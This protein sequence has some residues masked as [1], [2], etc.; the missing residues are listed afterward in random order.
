MTISR[1]K[2]ITVAGGKKYTT[3]AYASIKLLRHL[4]CDLPVDWFYINE[5]E[6]PE[7]WLVAASIPGVQCINLKL[8]EKQHNGKSLGGW[9]AKI[10]AIL[11]TDADEVLYLDADNFVW[12]DPEYLFNSDLFK[13]YGAI[14][15]KDVTDWEKERIKGLERYFGVA[16]KHKSQAE[17]GQLLFDKRRCLKA[18]EKVREYNVTSEETYKVVYGDKDTFYFGLLTTD[19]PFAFINR[20]PSCGKGCLLQHDMY[21]DILFTHLTGG[22]WS[23]NGRP[24]TDESSL[25][26]LNRCR[27]FIEELRKQLL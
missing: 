18:L 20:R 3:N 2:I 26:Y 15:W 16:P 9:Q 25:P 13:E 19:T 23:L 8:N 17:S 5:Q 12:R 27:G 1:R 24:F 22:K 6:M 10:E 11:A 7:K 14:L 21:D 4:G